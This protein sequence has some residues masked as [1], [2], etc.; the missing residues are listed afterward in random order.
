MGNRRRTVVEW[1]RVQSKFTVMY[2]SHADLFQIRDIKNNI[3]VG[4]FVTWD[5]AVEFVFDV[6]HDTLDFRMWEQVK[7]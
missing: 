7:D 2:N 5:D 1:F 3:A 6:A 4:A